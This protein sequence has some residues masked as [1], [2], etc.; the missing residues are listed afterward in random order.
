MST[1]TEQ[2]VA[3]GVEQEI[4]RRQDTPHDRRPVSLNELRLRTVVQR[5]AATA[6]K[7]QPE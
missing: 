1:S 2:T 4:L 5:R 6:T 3:P 7:K